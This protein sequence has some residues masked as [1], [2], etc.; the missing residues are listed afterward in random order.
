MHA[1]MHTSH[2]PVVPP[3]L[4]PP[5]VPHL[6]CPPLV[7]PV[8][9]SLPLCGA[10][11]AGGEEDEKDPKTHSTPLTHKAPSTRKLETFYDE[12]GSYSKSESDNAAPIAISTK[13]RSNKPL[14]SSSKLPGESRLDAKEGK[15][16][17]KKVGG[18][19][20][21]T[22]PIVEEVKRT[23]E[24]AKKL[25]FQGLFS[26]DDEIALS[27]GM[28]DYS[29]KTGADP[30]TDRNGF[31]DFVN[32]SKVQLMDKKGED[33]TFSKAHEQKAFQLSKKIWGVSG[34]VEPSTAKSNGKAKGNNKA[35]AALK[36]ELPSSSVKKI[37]NTVPIEVDK[38]VSKSSSGLLDMKFSFSDTEV[39][40]VKVGLDMVDGE[41]K[42]ALKGKMEEIANGAVGVFC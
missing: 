40:V 29:A 5:P 8:A 9:D 4:D 13:P 20:M 19:G 33:P 37:D 10:I 18:E 7:T 36:A 1:C 15:R 31:Y 26:E 3:L 11:F 35:V 21:A 27:K 23:G 17:K 28:L 30:H 41:K 14:A 16:P 32:V 42:A 25:L 39:G 6:L 24:D 2:Q 12:S 22:A 38:V 34:K